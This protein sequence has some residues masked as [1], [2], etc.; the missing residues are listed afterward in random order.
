MSAIDNYGEFDLPEEK[1]EIE[2]IEHPYLILAKC[3]DDFNQLIK[4]NKEINDKKAY[5]EALNLLKDKKE[6]KINNNEIKELLDIIKLKQKKFNY[7]AA[8]L[9][10]SAVH[11]NLNSIKVMLI[12]NFVEK[13]EPLLKY[14][15]NGPLGYKLNSKKMLIVGPN[16]GVE[17]LGEY[18]KGT[19]INYGKTYGMAF[20][21]QQG[22]QINHGIITRLALRSAGGTRINYGNLK[23]IR[24]N[25]GL[26]IN[27]GK[28]T[29]IMIS[30]SDAGSFP[31]NNRDIYYKDQVLYQEKISIQSK[32]KLYE[33]LKELDFLKIM[34]K[35]P[36]E[37]Q[38]QK[39]ESFNFNKFE[40]EVT[41]IVNELYEQYNHPKPKTI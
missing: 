6:L 9:F 30:P 7:F 11:N 28:K 35:L 41:D 5:D 10:L 27:M 19:I 37:E 4:N 25:N 13:I 14:G 2:V 8:G 31:I 17:Q 32:Q 29:D 20:Y 39:V 22:L 12:D 24:Q 16:T 3:Y 1:S 40:K 34:N 38:I 21:S 33:K 15:V 18:S 26:N 23:W 36:E